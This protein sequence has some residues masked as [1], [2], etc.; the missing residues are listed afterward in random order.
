MGDGGVR[1]ER[2][3]GALAQ[4]ARSPQPVSADAA[5][6]RAAMEIA[7]AL[8]A[9]T[10]AYALMP[11]D[12]IA[13][14]AMCVS[15]VEARDAN[16]PKGTLG[17]DRWG[18]NRVMRFAIKYNTPWMRPRRVR[19]HT[20]SVREE[21]FACFFLVDNA[22]CIAPSAHNAQRGVT[23]GNPNSSMQALYAWWRVQRDCGRHVPDKVRVAKQLHALLNDH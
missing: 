10:S 9:D 1:P 4:Q 7:D 2:V 21:L 17:S 23:C 15:T 16:I 13:L 20:E 22:A 8:A 18:F 14:R 5:R 3:S 11:H 19:T 12:P 6:R